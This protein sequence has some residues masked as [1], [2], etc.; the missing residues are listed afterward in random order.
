MENSATTIS[1][2]F[3]DAASVAS[4]LPWPEL[5][6]ALHSAFAATDLSTPTRGHYHMEGMGSAGTPVLLSMPAWSPGLG[7][8]VKLVAV[9]PDNAILNLPSIHGLYVLMEGASG[10]PQAV[11]DAGELTARR[12]AAASALASRFLSR[13]DSRTLLMV[14]TGRLSQYLPLAHA[15]VRPIERVLV[16]GR[17]PAKAQESAD[18]LRA[19][20]VNAEPVTALEEASAQADIISCA[21]LSK[22]SLLRGE[23][24]RPGT[25]VDLVGAFTPQ[26][27]EAD[28]QV[29]LRAASVW[30]DTTAGGLAEAGD[31]IQALASGALVRNRIRGELADLC[32]AGAP[33]ARRDTDITV[34]KSVGAA[35]EDLA[36]ARLCL[37]RLS[38]GSAA[39]QA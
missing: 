37:D 5:L 3:V 15:Q 26:M 25:H 34:F 1:P 8:G 9:Y 6:Q 24:L 13:P 20:G 18:A 7:V 28:D 36:A 10:R 12:T 32:R 38:R 35:L 30:C 11:L 29:F 2:V 17:S 23:W 19:Q 27:R 4:H 14:G 31:L 22:T 33:I 39:P 16:W 21:T